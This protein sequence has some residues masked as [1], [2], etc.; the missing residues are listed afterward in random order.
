MEYAPIVLFVF[1]RPAHTQDL[2]ETLEKCRLSDK[3]RLII[4]ADGPKE[5]ALEDEKEKIN[6]VRRIVKSRK[7]CGEVEI[8]E[9]E[10]NR[11][12][13]NSIIAGVGDI[14]NKYGKAI[15][16][17]DD[18]HLS[19][20]FLEFMNHALTLYNDDEKVMHISGYMFPVKTKLPP[21]FFLMSTTCWGWATWQRSWKYF[22]SSAAELQRQLISSGRMD[23]FSFNNS[24]SFISQLEDNVSGKL[25][26]WAIKWHASV[27]LQSGLCLHPFPSLVRNSGNDG[28][29]TNGSIFEVQDQE[30]TDHIEVKPIPI[31]ENKSA[32]KAF[33]ILQRTL[34]FKKSIPERIFRKIIRIIRA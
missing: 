8:H 7:W 12:L 24:T 13:A 1:N 29:G 21:T 34:N 20:G 32:R 33:E 3:S 10:K 30:I 22:N 17:E 14:L 16:L 2:L 19:P 15:I 31:E 11:G 28:S 23:E 18:L 25:K 5:N 27:V 26:T 4:Y 9:S 6:E